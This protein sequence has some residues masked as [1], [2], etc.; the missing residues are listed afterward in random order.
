MADGLL[1]VPDEELFDRIV[2]CYRAVVQEQR[3]W[4]GR[5]ELRINLLAAGLAAGIDVW[6]HRHGIKPNQLSYAHF[7]S[8]SLEATGE[9]DPG[10]VLDAAICYKRAIRH[11]RQLIR[12]YWEGLQA[13]ADGCTEAINRNMRQVA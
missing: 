6:C 3:R 10:C 1:E 11:N 4:L 12:D 8:L 5:S 2:A 13:A 7:R 9:G